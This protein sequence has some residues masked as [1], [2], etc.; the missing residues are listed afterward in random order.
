MPGVGL[1]PTYPLRA[2]DFKSAA[3]T[4]SATRAWDLD[5]SHDKSISAG[6]AQLFPCYGV[7][8]VRK[9]EWSHRG[10]HRTNTHQHAGSFQAL[11]V[12][13]PAVRREAGRA[14]P[15]RATCCL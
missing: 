5:L 10:G 4:D 15:P 3:Y 1:E 6:E 8:R 9:E 12:A 14:H 7:H 13:A 2:T 11:S